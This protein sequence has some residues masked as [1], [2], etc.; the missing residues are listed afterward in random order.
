M[1][2]RRLAAA[3]VALLAVAGLSS[4][5]SKVGQAAVVG[6]HR[7][8]DS[9]LTTFVQAAAKSYPDP[10]TRTTVVPKLNALEVW[11]NDQL[12]AGAVQSHGGPV[13]SAELGRTQALVLGRGTLQDVTSH[14][15]KLGYTGRF[16]A[17]LV[18]RQQLILL[19]VKRLVPK[20][21][22]SQIASA[23]QNANVVRALLAAVQKIKVSVS[24]RYGSWDPQH[25]ALT[26]TRGAGLPGFV[27]FVPTSATG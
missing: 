1:R 6:G 20:I 13:T 22:D 24:G 15:D 19:L 9:D 16:S 23:L 7:L 10:S 8:S 14:F 27:S 2:L 5:T 25:I 18:H 4:C 17:L 11:I 3:A 26:Q 21:A 12:F